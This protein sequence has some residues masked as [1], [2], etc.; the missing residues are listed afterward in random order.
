M[1]R[2]TVRTTPGDE[3]EAH[4]LK[5][6]RVDR[7]NT[8]ESDLAPGRRSLLRSFGFLG[9]S[10]R[11]ATPRD[12][13]PAPERRGDDRHRVECLA[14]FGWKSWRRFHMLDALMIDLSRGGARIFLD[15]AP[16]TDRPVWVFIETPALNTIVKA[17]VLEFQTTASGQCVVRVA[18]DEPCPYGVFEAAVCGLAPADPKSRTAPATDDAPPAPA[19]AP[20]RKAAA[21]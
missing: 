21:G 19:P 8:G 13:R 16:P 2:T 10:P 17:R 18:F 15:S 14:W 20:V 11:P 9:N 6:Y 1:P 12:V 4:T 3:P 7:G 5:S